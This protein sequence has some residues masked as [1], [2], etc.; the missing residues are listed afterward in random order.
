[1]LDQPYDVLPTAFAGEMF[2]SLKGNGRGTGQRE[3]RAHSW[4]MHRLGSGQ[5]EG[6][7]VIFHGLLSTG[8]LSA[9]HAAGDFG[10][11]LE[12]NF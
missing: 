2:I 11:S 8:N 5:P 7:A 12:T 1:M 6:R 10:E 4:L 9:S 3:S